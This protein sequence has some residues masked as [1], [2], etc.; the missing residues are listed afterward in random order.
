MPR[1]VVEP[2]RR[3]TAEERNRIMCCDEKKQCQKPENLKDEPRDCSP[4]QV[5]ECHGSAAEHTCCDKPVET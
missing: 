4:E 1:R 3:D 2:R 5:T